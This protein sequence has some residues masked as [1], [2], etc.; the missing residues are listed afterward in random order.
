MNIFL[1]SVSIEE[2]R[3]ASAA[4]FAD[5]QG[6]IFHGQTFA[7]ISETGKLDSKR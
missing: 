2:I 5:G 4:G 7:Q 6:Q 3:N 1:E